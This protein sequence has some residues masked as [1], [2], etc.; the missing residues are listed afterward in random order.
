[1]ECLNEATRTTCDCRVRNSKSKASASH[2]PN[3]A[4]EDLFRHFSRELGGQPHF[5][6]IVANSTAHPARR[7]PYWLVSSIEDKKHKVKGASSCVDLL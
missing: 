3:L 4:K 1:M 5:N 6:Q 7:L 2:F